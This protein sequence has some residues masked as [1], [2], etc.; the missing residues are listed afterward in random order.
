[1]GLNS[2]QHF[3][4]D[5]QSI[6]PRIDW[7]AG[8]RGVAYLDWGPMPGKLWVR[9]QNDGGPYIPKKHIY[10]RATRTVDSETQSTRSTAVN[11]HVIR[12]SDV[13]LM[14]AEE[15]KSGRAHV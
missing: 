6:D 1:M 15:E 3:N 5:Q 9:D 2:N 10:Y 12:F 7:T 11:V 14:A 4:V 13:L 8:R